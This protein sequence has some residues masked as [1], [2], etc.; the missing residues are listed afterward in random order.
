MRRPEPDYAGAIAYALNRLRAELSPELTYHSVWHTEHDVMPAAVRLAHHSA[1]PELDTC[2]LEVA[3]AYHDLGYIQTSVEHERLGAATAAEVLPGYGFDAGSIERIA[4]MIQA[5]RLPQSPRTLAEE[6]LADADLDV[7][8]REDFL[9]RERDLRQEL[10]T[11]GQVLSDHDWLAMQIKLLEEH[12][13]FTGAARALRAAG[14]RQ[15][16]ALL[17]TRLQQLE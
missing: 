4:G 7:L 8:G 1:L 14:Q 16:L 15:H 17:M 6:I 11:Q 3:A 13:Y 10:A 2:L 9:A 12:T 5:T